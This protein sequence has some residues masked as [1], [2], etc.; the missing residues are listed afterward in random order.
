MVNPFNAAPMYMLGHA[1]WDPIA[2]KKVPF[3][4]RR[5]DFSFSQ[6]P[7]IACSFSLHVGTPTGA[8]TVSVFGR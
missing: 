4:W 6:Q 1:P 2:Y 7:L 5:L 3:P 8:V